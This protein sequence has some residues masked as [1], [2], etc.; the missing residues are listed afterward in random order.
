LYIILELAEQFE[1]ILNEITSLE[2]EDKNGITPLVS[3]VIGSNL[4]GV[5]LLVKKGANINKTNKNGWSSLHEA[6]NLGNLG[7]IESIIF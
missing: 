2:C 5:Q 7:K 6:I 1:L 4:K 3:A